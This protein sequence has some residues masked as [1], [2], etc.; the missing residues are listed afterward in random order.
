MCLKEVIGLLEVLLLVQQ[1]PLNHLLVTAT[2]TLESLKD[3]INALNYG[4]TASVLGAGDDTYTSCI[5][6]SKREKKTH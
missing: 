4:V 2:D 3:K 1:L 5:K 6:I